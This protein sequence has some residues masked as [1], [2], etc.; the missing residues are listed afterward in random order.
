MVYNSDIKGKVLAIA[1]YKP[2]AG[3]EDLLLM[4]VATHLPAL[5]KLELATDRPAYLAKSADGTIIEIFEWV[6]A[7]AIH[8]AHEHPD[9]SAIWQQMDLVADFL[10]LNTLPESEKVFPGFEIIQ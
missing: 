4:L 6:S 9:I 1:T 7:A 8:A 10:P 5:R 2:K 3:R